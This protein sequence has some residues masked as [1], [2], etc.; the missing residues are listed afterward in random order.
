MYLAG[1]ED[2]PDVIP[3]EETKAFQY[4]VENSDEFRLTMLLKA[5]SE[6]NCDGRMEAVKTVM[7]LVYVP[8]YTGGNLPDWCFD[9]KDIDKIIKA[10][11]KIGDEK[12]GPR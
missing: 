7:H 5:F 11:N 6:M 9:D 3:I 1:I 2:D 12:Y 10:I 4:A 8:E